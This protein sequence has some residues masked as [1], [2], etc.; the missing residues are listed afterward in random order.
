MTDK[1]PLKVILEITLQEFDLFTLSWL[2]EVKDKAREQGEVTL[3]KLI[4]LPKEV[5]LS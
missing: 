2:D 5:D 3:F 4:N 1:E